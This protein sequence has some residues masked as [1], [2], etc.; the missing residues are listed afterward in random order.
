M[1]I[2]DMQA[3]ALKEIFNMGVGRA[4]GTLSELVDAQV[5]LNIP[6][7]EVHDL[8]RSDNVLGD[9]FQASVNAVEQGFFGTFSGKATLAFP[10]ESAC[11]LVAAL[12]GEEL[13]SPDLDFAMSGT[14]SEVGNILINGVLGTISN[15][16]ERQINFTL[17]SYYKGSGDRI[18]HAGN[19]ESS[20]N[21]VIVCKTSFDVESLQVYGYLYLVVG[22]NTLEFMLE[23]INKKMEA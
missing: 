16:F 1:N 19:A 3:D 5:K 9:V 4:A 17:P 2:S 15:I 18:I 12:S 10:T 6:E 13:G 7:I 11:R 22:A 8:N 20:S 23:Q 21:I 14:L